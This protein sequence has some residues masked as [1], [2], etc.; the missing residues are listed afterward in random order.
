VVE[1]VWYHMHKMGYFV[2]LESAPDH[3]SDMPVAVPLALRPAAGS[4]GRYNTDFAPRWWRTWV[5]SID[6]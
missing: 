6:R 5:W 2:L 3:G 4:A 1:P